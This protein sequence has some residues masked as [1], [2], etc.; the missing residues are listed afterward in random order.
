MD[1]GGR[2]DGGWKMAEN[3]EHSTSNTEHPTSN[4]EAGTVLRALKQLTYHN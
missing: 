4:I 3:I 1:D 2:A